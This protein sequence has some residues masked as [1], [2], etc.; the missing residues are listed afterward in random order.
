[1]GQ[2]HPG[3]RARPRLTPD[4]RQPPSAAHRIRRALSLRRGALTYT[5]S[6]NDLVSPRALRASRGFLVLH[7]PRVLAQ[8]RKLVRDVEQL[9]DAARPWE[10]K[11]EGRDPLRLL[12]I[13]DSTA[14]GVGA[15]T[16]DEALP[17]AL[18]R[19][20]NART[21]R[22]VIWRAIGENGITTDAFL[23]RHLAAAV[24]RPADLVFVTLGANDAMH[25]R[26][27]R[28]FA[29]DIRELLTTVSDRQPEALVLM[30]NLPVFARFTLLP[31]PTRTVLYR[32]SRN[33]ERAAARVI[34]RDARWM[35]TEQ[36]PPPYGP[37]FFSRDQF[38]PS[39]SGYADWARWAVEEAWDRGLS[40]ITDAGAGTA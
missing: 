31:E 34:A 27:A 11:L 26:S 17:G 21:G 3:D 30:S 39:P 4:R 13:G 8:R 40:A 5:R 12:V 18:A 6:V 10:G 9:P 23:D 25:A 32:H 19:E 16:Q 2:P 35:I 28:A 24:S 20:L 15:A 22:G 1:M 14:A 33:L 36:L 29:R 38:H 7:G 37:D